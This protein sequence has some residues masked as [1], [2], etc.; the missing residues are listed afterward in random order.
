MRWGGMDAKG[1]VGGASKAA[2]G[3]SK[4]SGERTA[5]PAFLLR[6]CRW[7]GVS[8]AGGGLDQ[9]KMSV[10]VMGKGTR[11]SFSPP[12]LVF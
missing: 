12:R 9:H 3:L 8:K 7:E 5:I 10:W 1:G 6:A 11:P 2:P 4:V